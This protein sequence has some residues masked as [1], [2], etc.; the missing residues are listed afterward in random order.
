MKSLYRKLKIIIR[1]CIGYLLEIKFFYVLY[2]RKKITR[3]NETAPNTIVS[4][5]SYG[6][7]VKSC[8][9]FAAFSILKQSVKPEKI[10]LWLDK[11]KWNDNNLPKRLKILIPFG[12]TIKYCEDIRSYTKLLP[13]L[14]EF[15]DKTIITVDDDIWYAQETI[16]NLIENTIIYPKSIIANRV[17]YPTYTN[18][19]LSH[20]NAWVWEDDINRNMNFDSNKII[21]LGVGGVLYPPNSFNFEIFN[22]EIYLNKCPHA[23]D[24]WFYIMAIRNNTLRKFTKNEINYFPLDTF[25]QL[26]H[27]N[28]SLLSLNRSD[29]LESLDNNK[30]LCLLLEHYDIKL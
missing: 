14:K 21:A 30:Q 3:S 22:R 18:G 10:I 25:Y 26:T 17:G 23:D 2:I 5:T 28:S 19:I 15:P 11:T 20:W 12:L 8:A 29:N 24:I 4:L 6:R 13:A 7:R 16:N 9:P 27:K 1:S